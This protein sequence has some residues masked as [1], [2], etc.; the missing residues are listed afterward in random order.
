M[1]SF[2]AIKADNF[3]YIDKTDGFYTFAVLENIQASQSELNTFDLDSIG[4]IT[5]LYFTKPDI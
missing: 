5:L 1:S 3:L 2:R 4:L